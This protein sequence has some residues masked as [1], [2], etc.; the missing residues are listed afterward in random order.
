[1]EIWA[2]GKRALRLDPELWRRRRANLIGGSFVNFA[3]RQVGATIAGG[4]FYNGTFNYTNS[5]TANYGTVSGGSRNTAGFGGVVGGGD[6]NQTMANYAAIGGG[7][8]N[9]LNIYWPPSRAE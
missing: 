9:A 8:N 7:Q 5:V 4:G 1:M 2:N 6:N 3:S